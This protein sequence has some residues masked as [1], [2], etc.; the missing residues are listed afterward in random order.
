[1]SEKLEQVA[2]AIAKASNDDP[3]GLTG[4]LLNENERYWEHYVSLALAAIQ[5]LGEPTA[6]MLKGGMEV[7]EASQKM[8]EPLE[9]Q[10]GRVWWEM[11]CIA[12][13]M[14][15]RTKEDDEHW[16]KLLA[17]A[18]IAAGIAETGTPS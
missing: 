14:P 18:K 7:L 16:E 12:Q 13:P 4:S 5:E 11:I 6:E 15:E 17:E 9:A 2:R 3:D 1:M 10:V 8:G